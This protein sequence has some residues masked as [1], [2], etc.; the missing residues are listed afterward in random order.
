[1]RRSRL[2]NTG[3][4]GPSE[5]RGAWQPARTHAP[6]GTGARRPPSI[7]RSPSAPPPRPSP[8]PAPLRP[9]SH[10]CRF[11]HAATVPPPCRAAGPELA[12][13]VARRWHAV[14][15]VSRGVAACAGGAGGRRDARGRG[16]GVRAAEGDA[17]QPQGEVRPG[18]AELSG[19]CRLH[20]ALV[21]PPSRLQSAIS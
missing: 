12:A 6:T 21:T 20:A 11:P 13:K 10:P 1:M 9:P 7:S 8:A 14:R 16:R 17:A 18:L 4:R 15:V 3:G 19:P 2:P 5:A